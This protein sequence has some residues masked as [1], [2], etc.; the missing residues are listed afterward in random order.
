M[1]NPN[2]VIKN[3]I[4]LS[5]IF[6]LDETDK[7]KISETPNRSRELYLLPTKLSDRLKDNFM[8]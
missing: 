2:P 4:M 5:E 6:I 1:Q 7:F 3:Y 8:L